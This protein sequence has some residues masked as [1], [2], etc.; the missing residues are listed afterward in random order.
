MTTSGFVG[1]GRSPEPPR[2][3][4]VDYVSGAIAQLVERCN[5]TAEVSGSTPLSSTISAYFAEINPSEEIILDAF[6]LF[7]AYFAANNSVAGVVLD[8]LS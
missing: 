4:Q 7:T 5:R 8:V 3:V 1:T 6:S 2:F